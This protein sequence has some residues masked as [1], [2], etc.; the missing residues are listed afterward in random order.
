MPAAYQIIDHTYD[1]VVV[2]AGGSGL[3]ATMGIAEAGLKTACITKVFPTRSHTVAAQGGIAASLGNNSPDH[4]SWHMYDTVKG[5]DWLGDQDAIEYMVREAPAAVYELE[6]AGVPF[7]RNEDGTIYQRPFGGHM[8]NMGEG[9]PVQR[10][11]AAADRTGHAMLHALYQQ[12]LKYD[13]DFYIEFFALDL[14]MENGACRGV[15][16]L[17]METGQIHRFRA[18]AVVLATGGGGRVYQ[19][20]TSAHT[21][22]GDGNGM[23]LRAGLPL[24][25]MEFVQF[26]PTGIYGAG[27]LI[28]EGARGEGGYL[29]NSEGE[30]FME[31]YA[32]SA[33]DL[34]SRDVV[35]RSMAAEMR[36]GRGV[37]KDKDHIFLHLDHID[38]KVL[39]ERLPG[40]TETGKI[41]AGVDLTRQPLPVTPTVHYNMGGIP[42]NYHGE[43]VQLKDGDPDAVV[44]GLFAVGE[45]ACVSVHGA[46][47]LGSNSLIDLVVF[48]RATGLRLKETLKP[49]T[50]HNPLPKGSEEMALGR[51][52]HF[53]NSTGGSPT[54]KI[55]AEM[56]K[57]MQRHAAVFR[58]SELLA[59]GVTKIDAIY[60]SMEDVGIKDRS[61]IWNTDLVETL[62]L[63]N[64]IS[65]AVVTMRGAENRK[66]SRGAHMH[67]DYPERDDVNWMKHTIA[68][69]DG[70]GGKGGSCSLD[71]R[72]VHDYTL[73]DDAEYIKPKK[74]VY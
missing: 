66:E 34:A 20:A 55:R 74:R 11:C 69:F 12:S 17:N 58:D 30:R 57:T 63:D 54:A 38:P 47:R 56:Q 61:L 29:T 5:S 73:T 70:W 21:C 37:G 46:N 49:N 64:L 2:G 7:S 62:E 18:H 23:A 25:D 32:P 51:L 67:E 16:A 6:H 27:V 19:S 36:E 41:F 1:A 72:P 8:Q 40:I 35:S 14:I 59:E 15:I 33:K 65:Q 42:T 9:P 31:R 22:T 44:P 68:T 43:V 48:G 24:Q 60:K 26:H 45:A 13:A 50:P 28:T 52:D 71:Y 53:R 3:R 10:T 39:A 4:W